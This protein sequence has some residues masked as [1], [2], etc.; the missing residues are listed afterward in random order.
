[1][2]KASSI[3]RDIF[4]D[5]FSSIVVDDETLYSQIRDYLQIAPKKNQLSSFI[6]TEYQFLKSMVLKDK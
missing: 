2:N 6:I 3:L 4:N 1:M 5:T